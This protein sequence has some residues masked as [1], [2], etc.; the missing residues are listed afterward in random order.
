VS[1]GVVNYVEYYFSWLFVDGVVGLSAGNSNVNVSANLLTQLAPQLDTPVVSL[2]TNSTYEGNGTAQ[3]TLGAVDTTNCK[4]NWAF[5]P[6][7][8]NYY[9][10]ATNATSFVA[11]AAN[12]AVV[13]SLQNSNVTLALALNQGKWN[14]A[15]SQNVFDLITNATGAVWNSTLRTW[16]TSCNVS[17]IGSIVVN[18]GNDNQTSNPVTLTAADLIDFW[19]ARNVCYVNAQNWGG[20]RNSTYGYLILSKLSLDTHCVAYNVGTDQFGMADS[21]LTAPIEASQPD[22]ADTPSASTSSGNGGGSAS[23]SSGGS[24]G[25]SSDGSGWG[26]TTTQATVV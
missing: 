9:R 25:G 3:I 5:A 1:L 14:N 17:Q 22:G 16:L 23:S 13:G 24:N 7:L 18:L 10:Y 20:A 19:P 11:T 2:W 8:T 26:D 4:N 21:L 15:A 6:R 12:G